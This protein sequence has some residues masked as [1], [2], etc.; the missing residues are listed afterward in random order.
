MKRSAA[1]TFVGLTLAA[2]GGPTGPTLTTGLTGVVVRGPV[3][4][5]CQVQTPC[6]LPFAATFSVEESA[7]RV[8]EFRSDADGRFTVLLPQG[9]YRIVPAAD[10]PILSPQSQIKMVDV[11]PTG[12][13]EVRLEFDTGLR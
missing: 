6:E 7:R 10:A 11:Q 4:P 9:V 12:L 2:C 13:T 3:T 1:V 5:V 8:A